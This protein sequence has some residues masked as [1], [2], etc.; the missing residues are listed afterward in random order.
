VAEVVLKDVLGEVAGQL[1][2]VWMVIV[3]DSD[4]LLLGSWVSPDNK[5]PPESRGQFVNLLKNTIAAFQQSAVGLSRL[6]DMIVITAF[7]YLLIK[8]I[9]EGACF[10]VVDS[11][12]TVPLGMIMMAS[13]NY[14]PK[15]EAGIPGHELLTRRYGMGTMLP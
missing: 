11:P 3:A 9:C 2:G 13:N 1:P 6:E 4:G 14:T 5:L 7:S 8:P 10:L 15:L 12:R